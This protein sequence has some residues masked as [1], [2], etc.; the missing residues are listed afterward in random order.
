[1]EN[2]N[3]KTVPN[4]S[5]GADVEQ[6][7][8]QVKTS[9]TNNSGL[10]KSKNKNIVFKTF[11][12]EEL[13]DTVF[14]PRIPV[15]DNLLYNGTYIF[16]GA[17][18]I[19]KSF[20][21]AQIAYH[22]STG[23]DIWGYKVSKGT[24]LYLALE[25]DCAR[26]Q[27]RISRMFGVD[28]IDNLHIAVE[29]CLVGNGL[30]EQLERFMREHKDTKMIIVDTLQKIRNNRG[31]TYSYSGDYD[32]ITKLKAFSDK[33]GVCILVV[34]H[35]RKMESQDSFDMI[36]GTNGLMGSADGAFVLQKEKR[37]SSKAVLEV[38]GR[39]QPDQRV[40]LNGRS[41]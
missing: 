14:P 27:S 8:N 38:T 34:H 26:L 11:T 41:L 28:R 7:Y 3:K 4:S 12:A 33:Y 31:E 19:G 35:T 15:I 6:P 1:M 29:S 23:K 32:I 13:F 17:P 21:M 36:S 22:V 9:I 5:V 30:E 16:A 24:V 39:D 25:D 37:T 10:G 20:F 2:I 18:K 40:Y